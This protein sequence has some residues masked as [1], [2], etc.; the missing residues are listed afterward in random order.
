VT[1]ERPAGAERPGAEPGP[2][3]TEPDLVWF[4]DYEISTH[5]VVGSSQ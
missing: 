3:G 4:E 2:E 5:R 1:D